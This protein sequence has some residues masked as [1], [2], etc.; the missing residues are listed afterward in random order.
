[1]LDFGDVVI[2]VM[3][4]DQRNYYDLESFYGAAE[5]VGMLRSCPCQQHLC[6]CDLHSM[7]S[8]P[9]GSNGYVWQLVSI[10]LVGSHACLPKQRPF[11]GFLAQGIMTL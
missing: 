1:M 10:Q 7:L 2:H 5:E 9:F 3:S 6:P 11:L 8:F 4:E